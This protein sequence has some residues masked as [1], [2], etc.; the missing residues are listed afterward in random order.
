MQ[1]SNKSS[2]Q[3]ILQPDKV[4]NLSKYWQD[5]CKRFYDEISMVL[6]E[7]SIKPLTLEGVVGEKNLIV[8]YII[9]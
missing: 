8:I 2:F 4:D 3:I 6:P 1:I 7:G 5:Q 9:N